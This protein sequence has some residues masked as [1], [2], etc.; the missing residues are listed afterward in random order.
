MARSSSPLVS[1]PAVALTAFALSIS[2][3]GL[4]TAQVAERIE[5]AATGRNLPCVE[6]PADGAPVQVIDAATRKPVA[7]ALVTWFPQDAENGESDD[8]VP[9]PQLLELRRRSGKSVRTGAD[10]TTRVGAFRW[11]V[12][13]DG[14]RYAGTSHAL[15]G[16]T[17]VLELKPSRSIVVTTIDG[18]GKPVAGVPIALRDREEARGSEDEWLTATGADGR[19][20][21]GPLDL[22]TTFH[23]EALRE[24]WVAV[25]APLAALLQQRFTLAEIPPQPVEFKMPPTGRMVIDVVD[26]EGRPDE[27]LGSKMLRSPY[28]FEEERTAAENA[29]ARWPA[30]EWFVWDRRSH[31]EL[32]HVETGL[33]LVASARGRN[34]LEATSIVDGPK[35]AGDTVTVRLVIPDADTISARILDEKG[36]PYAMR[37][38]TLFLLDEPNRLVRRMLATGTTDAD[39]R[40]RAPM[41]IYARI[42]GEKEITR[43]LESVIHRPDGKGI[44]ASALIELPKS[45]QLAS[46]DVGE[47]RLH[48]PPLFAKGVVVDD[49]GAAVAG[50]SLR[51]MVW[52]KE[53]FSGSY[54]NSGDQALSAKSAGD[55]AFEIWGD[56][57]DGKLDVSAQADDVGHAA[58]LMDSDEVGFN[59]G[60]S[61]LRLVM[62][63]SGT[64]TSRV[65]GDL[66]EVGD[67][68][69]SVHWMRADGNEGGFSGGVN[70]DGSIEFN[71]PIGVASFTIERGGTPIATRDKIEVKPGAVIDVPPVELATSKHQV[72]LTIVD[73]LGK[74]VPA[75]WIALP[76]PE[77]EA[78]TAEMAKVFPPG[79]KEMIP[80]PRR[81]SVSTF[82]DGMF[83]L[84]SDRAIPSFA[85][86]AADR[87][88]V[89]IRH[90]ASAERVVLDPAP[91]VAL[92]V[93]FGGDPIPA[94]LLFLAKLSHAN[95]DEEWFRFGPEEMSPADSL[96]LARLEGITL[97]R[98]T[99]VDV[100]VRCLGRTRVDLLLGEKSPGGHSGTTIDFE[101]REV[102]V[103][104]T[105]E[106][107]VFHLK[108][109]RDSIDA[110]LKQRAQ[111]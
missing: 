27:T 99:P 53:M 111:R 14:D 58:P 72:E 33:R 23:T 68:G 4:A 56:A 17:L 90:A 28:D 22:F 59:V 48:A 6:S 50:A 64:I 93:E 54:L 105:S 9:E 87:T 70:D 41:S 26:G 76:D 31:H 51:V 65:I 40:L 100:P 45:K 16:R 84:R 8:L 49:A 66:E 79:F 62:W 67:L 73:D 30:V 85:V 109:S 37:E 57:P 108:V 106:R 63:R 92:V 39:G 94:P 77:E 38:V 88:A 83:T 78:R 32:P 5:E 86:G 55:G 20:A 75:G 21:I 35:S 36:D 12:A 71:A 42:G 69:L 47:I 10:G 95:D 97:E 60:A 18:A 43:F 19:V 2:L 80:L 29:G 46:F 91:R 102:E 107:Q 96:R 24:L 34:D 11:L 110:V 1:S 61:D 103:Q 3:P 104:R 101:P 44:L 82:K 13:S 81:P 89:V 7:G 25:D 74:P 98:A 15:R 52:P